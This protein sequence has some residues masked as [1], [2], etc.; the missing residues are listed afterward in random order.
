MAKSP[1]PAGNPGRWITTLDYP[2]LSLLFVEEG[3]V[4]ARLDLTDSGRVSACTIVRS[5]GFARLD[6][7]TCKLMSRRARFNAALGPDGQPTA[8]RYTQAV[9]WKMVDD[10]PVRASSLGWKRPAEAKQGNERGTVSFE[11]EIDETGNVTTCSVR[12]SS[13]YQSLDDETCRRL[14]E[15][16]APSPYQNERGSFVSRK[17]RNAIR[18]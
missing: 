5:S 1:I 17:V 6:E 14:R 10:Q 16:K 3:V 7:M 18:W 4:N 8:G 12:E 15:M 11:L 13:G 9:R 2:Q